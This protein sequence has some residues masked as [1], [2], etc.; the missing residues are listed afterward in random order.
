MYSPK[1]LLYIVLIVQ[2]YTALA[3][4]KMTEDSIHDAED[5]SGLE[6]DDSFTIEA[7]GLKSQVKGEI[8]AQMNGRQV[9]TRFYAKTRL[10][11]NRTSPQRSESP[12]TAK[13]IAT[14]LGGQWTILR[15]L[16]GT[17]WGSRTIMSPEALSYS[18]GIFK[19]K[20]SSTFPKRILITVIN[21]ANSYIVISKAS[22]L[23]VIIGE[24]LTAS[25]SGITLA[26]R[27]E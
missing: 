1:A 14:G 12:L 21:A 26:F 5:K 18:I 7:K 9:C 17:S 16:P 24:I 15:Y 19:A 13:G 3:A 22:S 2:V 10:K 23:P 20:N 6:S 11:N 8:D 4:F 25:N 27:F